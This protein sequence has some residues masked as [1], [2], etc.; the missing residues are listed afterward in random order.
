MNLDT[1]QSDPYGPE[2]D[3]FSAPNGREQDLNFL[4]N[5]AEALKNELDTIQRRI[6]DIESD[7]PQ[8]D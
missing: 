3:S 2:V 8:S 4:K 6:K 1:Y 5:E 7:Q